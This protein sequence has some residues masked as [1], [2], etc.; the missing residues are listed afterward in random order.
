[1]SKKKSN[2]KTEMQ[3][4]VASSAVLGVGQLLPANSMLLGVHV[5]EASFGKRKYEMST[6]INQAPIVHSKQT[7][8]WFSL[9]WK[10]ILALAEKAGIDT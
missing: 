1:M 6:G 4:P 2:G 8:K 10:D 7:G 5:G 3:N 9:S